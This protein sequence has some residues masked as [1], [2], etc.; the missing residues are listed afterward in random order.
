MLYTSSAEQVYAG[1]LIFVFCPGIVKIKSREKVN[2]HLR[3]YFKTDL[4]IKPR[5][6]QCIHFNCKNLDTSNGGHLK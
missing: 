4:L 3:L 5:D 2:F 6:S 1:A